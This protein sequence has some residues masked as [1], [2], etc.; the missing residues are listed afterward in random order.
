V[1]FGTSAFAEPSLRALALEHDV[2]RVV[3]QPDKPAG[4]GMRLTP[5]PVKA[6]ALELGLPVMT[7]MRLDAEAVAHALADKS[8][9]LICIAYGKILPAALLTGPRMGALNIHPS[10]L[11]RY[12]G[13]TPMQAALLA[14]DDTTAIS[15]IWMSACMDAGEIALQ[16]PVKIEPDENFGAL[17]DRLAVE[18]AALLIEALASLATNTL[19]RRPQDESQATYTKPIEKSELELRFDHSAL[20]LSRR[21]RAFAPKPGAWMPFEGGRLKVLDARPD[22]EAID[23][24]PGALHRARDGGVLATTAQDSL[25]LIKVVPEGKRP[26]SGEEFARSLRP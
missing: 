20:E 10:A 19:P 23:G 26:M 24:P 5:T 2:T 7:P 4:R 15:I 3:S 13:A 22:S 8:D 9:V 17:H 12:R 18:S 16:T 1:F 6:A 14:G 11:P 21:V 25:R